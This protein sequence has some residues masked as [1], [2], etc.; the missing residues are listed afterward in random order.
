[1]VTVTD[2]TQTKRQT[3][4]QR[5]R[6]TNRAVSSLKTWLPNLLEKGSAFGSGYKKKR[7]GLPSSNY[8]VPTTTNQVEVGIDPNRFRRE[9]VCVLIKK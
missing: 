6:Q 3:K 4:R 1:M 9:C 8:K 2:N 5:N 7:F